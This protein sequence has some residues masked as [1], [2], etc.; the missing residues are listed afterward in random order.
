MTLFHDCPERTALIT[1]RLTPNS[2]AITLELRPELRI[3]RTPSGVNLA[4]GLCAPRSIVPCQYRSEARLVGKDWLHTCM[5]RGSPAHSQENNIHK[6]DSQT[7]TN[8]NP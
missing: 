6:D 5:S 3:C 1:D 4:L 2:S 8:K 7:H